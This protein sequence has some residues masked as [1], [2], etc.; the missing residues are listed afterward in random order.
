MGYVALRTSR[1]ALRTLRYALRAARWLR[2]T[3]GRQILNGWASVLNTYS[4]KG[5]T[6]SPANK[7]YRYFKVSAKKYEG[8]ASSH[9][10]DVVVTDFK[11]EYPP[12]GTLHILSSAWKIS[13]PHS[14]YFGS[15]V[16]RCM[17]KIDS[18]VSGR[19]R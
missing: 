6:S 17:I 10:R 5:M 2:A 12:P 18:T 3:A 15:W 11:P 14:R 19:R 7:R 4:S 9:V 16:S 13:H 8:M 1:F